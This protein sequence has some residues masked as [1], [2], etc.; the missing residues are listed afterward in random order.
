MIPNTAIKVISPPN[1]ALLPYREAMKSA[2]DVIR[3]ALLIWMIF[4]STNHQAT[5]TRVGPR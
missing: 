4:D 3:F 2:I 5:K 1:S